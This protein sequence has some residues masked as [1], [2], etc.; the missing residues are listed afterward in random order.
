MKRFMG[1]LCLL[2]APTAWATTTVT[3]H[4]ADLGGVSQTSNTFVRF[5]LRGCAGGTPRVLGTALIAPTQGA[6]WFK[7]FAADSSGNVSGTIYSTRDSTG[8]LAG[9]IDCNGS[10]LAVWYGMTIWQGGKSGP[11]IPVHAKSGATLDVSSVTP[12]TT[13]PVIVAPTGDSTYLRLD[14]GNSPVT[15][16]LTVNTLT[17]PSPVINGTPTGTGIPTIFAKNGSGGGNYAGTNTTYANVDATNLCQIVTIPTGWKLNILATGGIGIN[18]AAVFASISVADIG[19]T[20]AGGGT[21]PLKES[22]ILPAAIATPGPFAVNAV[23]S[24]D[25]AAHAISL[26]AKT[27]NVADGWFVQNSSSTLNPSLILTLQPS[28]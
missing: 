15:G 2:L 21:T 23:V 26:Q 13:N 6:T 9:D 10:R 8:L 3:G 7:D 19:T 25:G 4:V 20:C 11:E 17:A 18:T 12:I 14:A 22:S 5:T 1:L 28:N 16:P 27:Q 24:G